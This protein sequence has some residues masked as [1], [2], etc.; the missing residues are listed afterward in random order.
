VQNAKA[1]LERAED[2]IPR[3][4]RPWNAAL[5]C[6]ATEIMMYLGEYDVA[7]HYLEACWDWSE[8]VEGLEDIH[9]WARDLAHQLEGN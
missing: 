7:G 9:N 4:D 2:L 5:M 6:D 8:G 3:D 1:S